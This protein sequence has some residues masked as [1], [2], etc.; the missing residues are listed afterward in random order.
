M[1]KR[2]IFIVDDDTSVRTSLIHLLR[3]LPDHVLREFPSGDAFLA[4]AANLPSGCLLLDLQMPG[5]GGLGVLEALAADTAR[6]GTV[7]LTGEG[8]VSLAVQAM[9]LGALDFLEKP[10]NHMRLF[11]AIDMVFSQLTQAQRV[12]TRRA[13]AIAKINSLSLRERDVLI[14]LMDGRSNKLIAHDLGISPRTIEIYRA[15]LM[16]KLNVRSLSEALGI[17]FAAGLYPEG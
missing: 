3:L 11:E 9:K 10:C 8:D 16:E 15:K 2:N 14:G 4:E 1:T 7:V 6:F 5:T 12:V 17:A 13:Q